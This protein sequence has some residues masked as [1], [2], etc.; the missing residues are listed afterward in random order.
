M[1]LLVRQ[2][3]HAFG[4]SSVCVFYFAATLAGAATLTT[5]LTAFP[6]RVRP[7]RV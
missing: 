3:G 1:D 7:V 2:N 5:A 6:K 4:D